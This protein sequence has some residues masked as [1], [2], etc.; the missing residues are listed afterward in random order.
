MAITTRLAHVRRAQHVFN[1]GS[2]YFAIG[3]SSEWMDDSNPPV[4]AEDTTE[5]FEVIGFRKADR[6]SFVVPDDENGTIEYLGSKY[7]EVSASDAEQEGAKW[8]WF[9]T[10]VSYEELPTGWYRQIGLYQGLT[11]QSTVDTGKYNL[12]PSE[13][14]DNGDLLAFANRQPCN[15]LADQKETF[16][17]I[18]EF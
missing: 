13:V 16:N 14:Q 2:F 8:I 5:L 9:S 15:R 1:L 11:R 4:E 3:K 10:T 7:R 12:L 18:I 17:I 6:V